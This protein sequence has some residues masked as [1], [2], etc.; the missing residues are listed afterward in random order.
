V[1]QSLTAAPPKFEVWPVNMVVVDLFLS[2]ASQWQVTGLAD[3]R[4]HWIGLN[5][6]GVRA[7]LGMSGQVLSPGEWAGV[8]VMERAAAA[9][10]NGVRG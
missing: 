1:I 5:Y 8:Q 9:A 7:G 6:E 4:L 2:I 10:L 3:G